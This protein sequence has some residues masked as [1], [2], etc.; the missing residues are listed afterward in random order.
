M[1]G[2]L[3]GRTALITGSTSGLGLGYARALAA[4]GCA[5]MLNGFGEA[6]AIEEARAGLESDFGVTAL[7]NGADMRMPDQVTA[8]VDDATDRLGKVDILINNAGMQHRAPAEDF[9]PEI[10]DDMLAVNLSAPFHAA[11]FAELSKIISEV[12][13]DAA[14]RPRLVGPDQ[15]PCCL[16]WTEVFLSSLRS[17][18]VT[19]DAFTCKYKD[20]T[21]SRI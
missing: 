4:E 3:D 12:W 19:L 11:Q 10:W 6:D 16:E 21:K 7:Y 9:P 1:P 17:H 18:N 8:M 15:N 14:V 20:T 13:S 5:I 2:F